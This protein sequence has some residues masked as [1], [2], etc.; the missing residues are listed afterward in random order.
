MIAKLGIAASLA[1]TVALLGGCR[2][3]AAPD[4]AGDAAEHEAPEE[5]VALS[6]DEQ[7]R[8]GVEVAEVHAATYQ[9]SVIGRAKVEDAQTVVDAMAALARAEAN[10]RTSRAALDRA[11]D[12]FKLDTAVSA[13]K[14]EGA[15]RQSAQDDSELRSARAHAALAFG[16]T[17]PWLDSGRRERLLAA[18]TDGSVLLVSASFPSGFGGAAPA[19][20][21]LRRLGGES[22][23]DWTATELWLGPADPAVPGPTMLALL[24]AP[25]GLSY[26][27][28]LTAGVAAGEPVPGVVVPAPAVVLAGGEPWCFVLT[29]DDVFVRRRVALDR[30]LA[31]GYFH[32][33]GF[34]AGERVVVAG[35]GL[36]LARELGG[37]A[38]AA[39]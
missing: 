16:P 34:A 29:D 10:A 7:V 12:L 27:E 25:R 4:G 17:A 33:E 2:G 26:G 1:I 28:R 21:T 19:S 18:L 24:P 15:E 11:R 9:P 14:L 8:L 6:A 38:E 32:T 3:A 5:G 35:A 30:P 37:G 22:G 13:E 31:D 23:E 36:L 20:L 39:D